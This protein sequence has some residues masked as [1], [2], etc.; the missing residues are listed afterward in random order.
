MTR[1]KTLVAVLALLAGTLALGPGAQ[2]ATSLTCPAPAGQPAPADCT[3]PWLPGWR[4]PLGP[5]FNNPIGTSAQARAI[6]TRVIAAIQHTQRGETIRIAVYSFD[7]ADVAYWL[8]KAKERGVRVQMVVNAAVMSSVAR[9]LQK[10]LGSNPR[11]N[12]FLVA[13]SGA[14][15]SAGDG[16]NLHVKVY[17]FSRTGGARALVIVSSGNLTSKAV[18]RQWNDSVAVAN[19]T[20][21]FKAWVAMF[22]QIKNQRRVGPRTITYSTASG[23]FSSWMSRVAPTASRATTTVARYAATTDPVVQRLRKVGCVAPAGYGVG[24]RTVIRVTMYAMFKT[25]GEAIARELARLKRA[26]C[27]IKMILSVPGGYTTRI[28]QKAGIPLRSADWEFAE[29]DPQLEDGIGGYGPRIYSHL[30]V[31]ALNGR[32][33]GKG[34]RTVWTGSENWSAI[35]FANE[36]I[37]LQL[38]STA[39]YRAYL[40][41][42]DRMWAGRATHRIGLEPEYGP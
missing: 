21:L 12:S 26:G 10:A 22:T 7:R 3:L 18:Y 15:R 31:M 37:T 25:R 42:F 28:L 5:V 11:R 35:S 34:T 27:R 41:K 17:S 20:G 29:R 39:I 30:K 2:A 24:G 36:E 19:D 16:G 38:N 14:C 32:Y 9:K 33:A 8:R 13:C 6:V 4:P 40:A 1:A 23:A